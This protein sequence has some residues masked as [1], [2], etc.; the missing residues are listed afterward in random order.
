MRYCWPAMDS[1]KRWIAVF[2]GKSVRDVRERTEFTAA[3]HGD[4]A[5]PPTKARPQP[6][7]P[8]FTQRTRRKYFLTVGTSTGNS[9]LVHR[10]STVGF[11]CISMYACR[12]AAPAASRRNLPVAR[13]LGG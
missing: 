11:C 6:S 12:H 4:Q 7:F 9:P 1:W 3:S 5:K 2:T 10:F 8:A 13:P